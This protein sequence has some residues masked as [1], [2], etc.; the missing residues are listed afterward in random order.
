MSELQASTRDKDEESKATSMARVKL[1]QRKRILKC[2]NA[3]LVQ[4]KLSLG[5]LG[6]GVRIADMGAIHTTSSSRGILHSE[7]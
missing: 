6:R 1:T 7:M 5:W 3:P 4:G 2:E